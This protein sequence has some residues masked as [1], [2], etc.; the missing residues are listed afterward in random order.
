MPLCFIEPQNAIRVIAD[1]VGRE[2]RRQILGE[3]VRAWVDEIPESELESHYAKAVADL[4]EHD[5]SMLAAWHASLEVGHPVPNK[6]FLVN[7][8][9]S[10]GENRREALKIAAGF[11][12]EEAFEAGVGEEQAFDTVLPWLSEERCVAARPRVPRAVLL[13][14]AG[15]RQL[16]RSSRAVCGERREWREGCAARPRLSG[17]R[18]VVD[19]GDSWS[20]AASTWTR[21]ESS[22]SSRI[23]QGQRRLDL[24]RS[25][26]RSSGTRRLQV[27]ARA[28]RAQL[29][30]MSSTSSAAPAL[31]P[32]AARAS[33]RRSA[34]RACACRRTRSRRRRRR[35]RRPGAWRATAAPTRARCS[36]R[37]PACS[38]AR[39]ARACTRSSARWGGGGRSTARRSRA[40]R[41]R[42]PAARSARR[43]ATAGSSASV[44]RPVSSSNRGLAPSRAAIAAIAVPSCS[45]EIPEESWNAANESSSG[46]VSTP[47]KSLMIASIAAHPGLPSRYTPAPSKPR[48]CQWNGCALNSIP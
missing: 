23:R 24:R 22:P 32:R 48:L 44:I 13:G 45:S 15:Q 28:P 30:S 21:R 29:T 5:L 41:P 27:R 8:F 20:V 4:D 40:A 26:A 19:A 16:S 25:P 34:A 37:S 17:S 14:P 46:E 2:A 35:S 10:L 43:R 36:C 39:A 7:V 42:A 3:V 9:P 1:S 33:A 18:G 31:R 12:G 6:E 11:R 47:P 38:R